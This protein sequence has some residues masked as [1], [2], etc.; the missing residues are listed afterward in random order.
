MND[1]PEI[2]F[3]LAVFAVIAIRNV[4]AARKK[5]AGAPRVESTDP[6]VEQTA[7]QQ[8]RQRQGRPSRA[9]QPTRTG[10]PTRPPTRP[11]VE[12]RGRSVPPGRA[13]KTGGLL[14]R[15]AELA[16]Q[17][18]RELEEQRAAARAQG[19]SAADADATLLVPG[20]RVIPAAP[21][22]VFEAPTTGR[23]PA[24]DPSV[25]RPRAEKQ[26]ARSPKPSSAGLDRLEAYDP[27]RRAIILSELLGRPG[28]L[29]GR[30][31]LDR[32]ESLG[33]RDPDPSVPPER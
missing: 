12:P 24:A 33:G 28:G 15:F 5:A 21:Q 13:R 16:K 8:E 26:V 19:L 2:L 29:S 7:R 27:L 32:W 9:S 17:I 14:G 30:S 25:R 10:P 11:S 1:F 22:P 18:E 23:R 3:W 31:V 6:T 20:R 4:A